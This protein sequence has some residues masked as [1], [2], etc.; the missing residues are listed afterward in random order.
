MGDDDLLQEATKPGETRSEC[1]VRF[2]AETTRRAVGALDGSC[3]TLGVWL[4]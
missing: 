1:A 2:V 3:L 4:G